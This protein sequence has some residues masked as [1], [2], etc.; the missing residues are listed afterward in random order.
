MCPPPPLSTTL[1]HVLDTSNTDSDSKPSLI[2]FVKQ[3][4]FNL[5]FYSIEI[6][7]LY[8]LYVACFRV[9]ESSDVCHIIWLIFGLFQLFLTSRPI[10]YASCFAI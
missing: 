4:Y 2:I 5:D 1:I 9:L 8:C 10:L 3:F 6:F 7:I